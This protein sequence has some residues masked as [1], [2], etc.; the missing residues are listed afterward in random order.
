MLVRDVISVAADL[1]G[2]GDLAAEAASPSE[3]QSAALK[4]EIALLVRCFNL[5][6]SDLSFG[7]FPLRATE[8]FL[9]EDGKI[10]YTRFSHAPIGIHAVTAR[11]REVAFE[12]GRVFLTLPAG[13]GEVEV[14]YSYA[15]AVKTAEDAPEQGGKVS[16]R[17][18]ALG[19]A[20]EFELARGHVTEAN[21]LEKRYRDAIAAAGYPRRMP[22]LR[23]R[24]WS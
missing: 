15:P 7:C 14:T 5:V 10:E 18:L 24:R 1:A 23:A 9:P 6:E 22:V 20:T 19:T 11:G 2:R 16:L 3:E 8:R 4:E 13:T 21:A 17:L 12:A